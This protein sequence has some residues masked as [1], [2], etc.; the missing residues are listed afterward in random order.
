M[1]GY[2]KDRRCNAD[3]QHVH[4]RLTDFPMLSGIVI[5]AVSGLSVLSGILT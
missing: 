5:L 1:A 2:T 3:I 4:T